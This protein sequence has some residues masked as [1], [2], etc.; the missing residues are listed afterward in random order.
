MLGRPLQGV[1]VSLPPL[2]LQKSACGCPTTPRELG[3]FEVC[4]WVHPQ[5]LLT[6]WAQP[7][8]EL[9]RACIE[10]T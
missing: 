3:V 1:C 8:W 2:T 7:L 4:G 10:A 5:A 9:R 6:E